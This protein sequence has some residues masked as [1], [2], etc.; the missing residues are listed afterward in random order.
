[1]RMFALICV[2]ARAYLSMQTTGSAASTHTHTKWFWESL[3]RHMIFFALF[4][5]PTK[6]KTKY[7]FNSSHLTIHQLDLYFSF[8]IER[9]T[10]TQTARWLVS[11]WLMR[12]TQRDR[13]H[14]LLAASSSSTHTS[15]QLALLENLLLLNEEA[16]LTRSL[17]NHHTH[18]HSFAC[19]FIRSHTCALALKICS[20]VSLSVQ[21]S[22]WLM[23]IRCKKW[24]NRYIRKLNWF[25]AKPDRRSNNVRH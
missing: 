1:M 11:G 5:C 17:S 25:L 12:Y 19:S 13:A 10:H 6:K 3:N 14:N 18:T 21:N 15:Q 2:C 23:Q 8:Q 16:A 9:A 22:R 7:E 20:C 24:L 4:A